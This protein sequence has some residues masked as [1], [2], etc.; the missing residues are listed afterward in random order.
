MFNK[1]KLE[2]VRPNIYMLSFSR[3]KQ[4]TKTFLRLQEHFESPEF[5]GKVFTLNEFKNWY[6]TTQ[7]HGKFSYYTDWSGFNIPSYI[8]K[9]FY[10]GDFNP[11]SWREKRL[12]KK[13]KPIY[14]SGKKFYLIGVYGKD[15]DERRSTIEHEIRHGLYYTDEKYKKKVDKILGEVNLKKIFDYLKKLGYASHV[16][17]DEAHAYLLTCQKHLERAGID[18]SKYEKVIKKLREIPI[19]T[20]QS[21]CLPAK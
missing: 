13:I 1:M 11:L 19:W 20:S 18:L 6:K 15:S 16:F 2:M 3:Q 9:P 21:S 4:L 17:N 8:L 14:D 12:L 10:D 5:T 7:E